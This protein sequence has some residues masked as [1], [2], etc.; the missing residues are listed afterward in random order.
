METIASAPRGV[1]DIVSTQPVDRRWVHRTAVSEVFLT[2]FARTS[3]STFSATC[4]LP[5]RHFYFTD[6]ETLAVDP[7]LLLECCR[8]AETC[9]AHIA[10]DVPMDAKFVLNKWELRACGR[11]LPEGC[12]PP[13]LRIDIV[14]ELVRSCRTMRTYSYAM[15][16]SIGGK[17]AGEA[18]MTATYLSADCYQ[19]LRLLRRA[20]PPPSS[21]D[22]ALIGVES[23]LASACVG[24]SDP[25]NIL[26]RNIHAEPD[27]A[28]WATLHVP[29]DHPS[30]FDH[31]LDHVPGIG[32]TEAA[33]Q[34][35]V[36]ATGAPFMRSV[37]ATFHRFVELDEPAVVTAFKERGQADVV[38]VQVTQ[39]GEIAAD[40][41]VCLGHSDSDPSAISRLGYLG[42]KRTGR[43]SSR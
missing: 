9:C 37:E 29:V 27:G 1:L 20:T 39:K 15:T 30:I 3:I 4:Q 6:H 26:L 22:L 16:L 34:L 40:F 32:V 17:A 31:P 19:S 36:A 7:M 5:R 24:R 25:G 12:A 8:Q 38:N 18:H 35:A 23:E 42:G 10:L 43:K 41:R 2:D 14:V 33:K 21:V 28:R 13:E 11:L